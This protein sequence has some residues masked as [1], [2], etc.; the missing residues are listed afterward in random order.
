[1]NKKQ[2]SGNV[3]LIDSDYDEA[4][5]CVRGLE[6]TTGESWNVALYENNKIYGAKRYLKFFTVAIRTILERKK[7]AGKTVLCWQQFYGIAIAF[8]SRLFHMKKR[9]KLVVMTFIYKPKGGLAGNIFYRFVK[10]AVTSKY[11]DKIILTTQSEKEM[12][13]EIF[14]VSDDVF[15][16]ARCGAVAYDPEQFE[17]PVLKDRG[18]I[19]STGRSNR[20]YEFLMN[21]VEN[22]EYHLI[23]ACDSLES[24][25]KKN[26]EIKRD[27]FGKDM[28][29]YMKNAKAVVIA[30][31][32]DRIAAG[33]LVFLHA[34]NMGVPVIITRSHGV[35]DDYVIDGYNGL[36]I[37]KSR[38]SLLSALDKIFRDEELYHR[39]S[40]NGQVEFY[41]HYTYYAM[42][43]TIGEIVNTI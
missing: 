18:Y 32:D 19:F 1:M 14:D 13:K 22:T 30:L 15:G 17:D 9:F 10:Y 35:T 24:D 34:M 3:L 8:F 27:V 40:E 41:S 38:E 6:E 11:V 12:Y 42:G 25:S 36:V 39:L 7:Y 31:D 43:K 29:R 37:E 33:Q 4:D 5:G 23:I 21:A 20:D 28:L 26:I 16:F 2:A